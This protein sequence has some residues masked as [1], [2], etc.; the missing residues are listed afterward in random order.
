MEPTKLHCK[1]GEMKKFNHKQRQ[2]NIEALT[3]NEFDVLIVGGGI[4]G[5]GIAREAAFRGMKVALIEANDFASG[6]SSRSSKLIHGGIRYLENLE[7]KLV[8]EALN[9]RSYLFEMAPHLV[10]PLQFMI[11]LFKSSRVG[12]FK[13]GLGMWLYDVLALF[14]TPE[15]H[16]RLNSR[17]TT[18][19]QP[20]VQSK[21]LLGSYLYYDAYMD[22]DRLVLETLRSAH[23]KGAIIANYIKAN[24][25]E[26]KHNWHCF[27]VE[28]IIARKK[29]SIK[30]KHVFSCVGP[31][32]DL[33]GPLLDNQ[34]KKMLRPTKGIHLIIPRAKLNLHQA[35][36]MGAEAGN[37]IIFGIP[38]GEFTII[39]T[40]DTDFK[41]NPADVRSLKEDVDYLLKIVKS[42]F[43]QTY[44]GYDDIISSYSGVRPLVK[45]DA[46]STGK[47]SREHAIKFGK[48]GVLFVTGGKYT[49]YRKI[50]EEAVDKL[51]QT[52]PL[53]ERISFKKVNTKV[54][55][56]SKVTKENYGYY[57]SKQENK[58]DFLLA[59]MFGPEAEDIKKSYYKYSF[60][61]KLAA[62]HIDN[63]MCLSVADLYLRRSNLMLTHRDHGLSKFNEIA[64]VFKEKLHVTDLFLTEELDK[65][66]AHIQHEMGW[67]SSK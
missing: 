42:Y 39:G 1:D 36:V 34:W 55:L 62:F 21:D 60:Y 49:T 48:N 38:R 63:T 57:M 7:F 45:D 33:F 41:E 66:K 31:W 59:E 23:E 26:Y 17:Q 40:T 2:K 3:E 16:D 13:M 53:E 37:R 9:E 51:L 12:M 5:A 29:F 65:I 6:T 20:E 43:P 32:T 11:P 54:P 56:N 30:A 35:V 47:T 8:F 4:N 58:D 24:S 44:I 50:A 15:I 18:D 27:D 67:K 64:E 14:Q 10:H 28:D 22:D 46:E 19:L 25:Y 61:Q 52:L